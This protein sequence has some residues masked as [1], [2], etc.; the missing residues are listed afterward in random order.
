MKERVKHEIQMKKTT[1]LLN[2]VKYRLKYNI[3]Q[4]IRYQYQSP[5]DNLELEAY[6][7][8][9]AL[10]D[11]KNSGSGKINRNNKQNMAYQAHKMIIPMYMNSKNVQSYN[12]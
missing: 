7:Q 12:I 9:D 5:Q 10:K 6:I 1:I 4:L 11:K 2:G 8:M 3:L